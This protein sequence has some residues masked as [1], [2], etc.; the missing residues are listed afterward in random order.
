MRRPRHATCPPT[1]PQK[2]QSAT[3]RLSLSLYLLP[4]LT[5]TRN[6]DDDLVPEVKKHAQQRRPA[7][8]TA[9][10]SRHIFLPKC[11]LLLLLLPL[12][13]PPPPV[14]PP[15]SP[16]PYTLIRSKQIPSGLAA[17]CVGSAVPLRH[18][19]PVLANIHPQCK[20]LYRI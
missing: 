17:I 2:D 18:G 1:P 3:N 8:L 14:A 6:Q 5:F 16:R 15:P 19:T 9:V 12:S 4:P 7:L 13:P 10:S 20:L 11:N